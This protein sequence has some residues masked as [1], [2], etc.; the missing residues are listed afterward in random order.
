MRIDKQ[1]KNN[2][3]GLQSP[4]IDAIKKTGASLKNKVTSSPCR[5]LDKEA[6]CHFCPRDVDHRN[7][8]RVACETCKEVTCWDQR[9]NFCIY[10]SK[11]I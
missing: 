8:Y 1:S 10:C 6:R 7:K 2:F 3:S 4:I 5:K 9:V 11:K